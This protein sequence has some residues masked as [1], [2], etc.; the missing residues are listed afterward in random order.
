MRCRGR[1][2]RRGWRRYT[3]RGQADVVPRRLLVPARRRER[4]LAVEY[5][6][7][8]LLSHFSRYVTPSAAP[9]AD[10]VSRPDGDARPH[11]HDGERG[12]HHL[13][14]R[15]AAVRPFSRARRA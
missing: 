7:V 3:R 6:T 13:W 5:V 10:T 14:A 1:D 8:D 4:T 9:E 15:F 2:G 11:A 12:H